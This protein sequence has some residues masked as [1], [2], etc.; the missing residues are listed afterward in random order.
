MTNHH[1]AQSPARSTALA[2][3]LGGAEDNLAAVPIA[4]RCKAARAAATQ[5]KPFVSSCFRAD[6]HLGGANQQQ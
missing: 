4:A 1:L 3:D 5:V 2:H 6:L